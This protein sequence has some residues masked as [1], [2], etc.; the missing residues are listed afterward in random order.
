[1][2]VINKSSGSSIPFDDV[3]IAKVD[4]FSQET[5]SDF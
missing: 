4:V 3:D 5:Q 1:M 2:H